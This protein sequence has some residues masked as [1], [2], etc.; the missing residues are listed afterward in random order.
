MKDFLFAVNMTGFGINAWLFVSCLRLSFWPG[1]FIHVAGMLVS[2][3]GMLMTV[4][5]IFLCWRFL[6][7]R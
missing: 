6:W 2:A 3:A 5:Y 4:P 7:T 1:A